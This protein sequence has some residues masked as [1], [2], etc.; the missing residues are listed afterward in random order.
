MIAARLLVEFGMEP[1]VAIVKVRQA[2]P[3][4]IQ[5]KEQE[6]YVRRCRWSSKL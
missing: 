6:E 5:T 3:G 1:N 4:A 2:R